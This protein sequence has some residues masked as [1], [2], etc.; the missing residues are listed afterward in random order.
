MSQN[1]EKAE[2]PTLR[3]LFGTSSRART[4]R[5]ESP[6]MHLPVATARA[7]L[8]GFAAL[9]LDVEEIR[10]ESGIDAGTLERQDAELAAD[11]FTR[12]WQSALRRAPRPELATEV[13]LAIPFGAFG[14]LDYLAGTSRD[15]E[16]GF[17]TLATHFRQV[18]SLFSV[19]VLPG[20]PDGGIVRLAWTQPQ[21]S[22]DLSDEFTLAVF[23]G[24]FRET[25]NGLFRARAVRLPTARP[26]TPTRHEQL[27]GAPVTFGCAVAALEVPA[28]SWK[29]PLRGADPVLQQTLRELAERLQLGASESDLGSALRA[30]LR[31]L[32]PEG[33]PS[34]ALVARLLGLSERT[35]QRRLHESGTSFLR[36]LDSFREAEAE[37]L[38]GT[39]VPL[40]DA[41][42]RL[43]FSDQSAWNRAFRRWKGMSPRQW[44]L[45][46]NAASEPRPPSSRT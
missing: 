40:A 16:A 46:R 11:A 22:R 32:L 41:A 2:I 3:G 28:G 33:T 6:G 45:L 9:G 19:E 36:V 10:V 17:L 25:T 18:S 27:L 30:R 14:A 15:V 34:A 23:I 8:V 26:A 1:R 7:V 20:E 21:P 5:L 13:G 35:L 42:L 44:T 24:R 12:L 39:G 38:L 4:P 43:G 37:R 29:L 31:S